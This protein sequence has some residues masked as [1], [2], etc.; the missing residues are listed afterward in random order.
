[1]KD[2][3]HENI[4]SEVDEKDIYDIVSMSL[5][6]NKECCKRAFESDIENIYII[7]NQNGMTCIHETK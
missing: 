3:T 7:K 4:H 5:D 6:E 1:M 2:E